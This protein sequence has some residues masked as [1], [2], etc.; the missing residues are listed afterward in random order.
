MNLSK[1][2]FILF[3]NPERVLSSLKVDGNF[4][5]EVRSVRYLGLNLDSHLK[6]EEHLNYVR[7]RT[8]LMLFALRR[9]RMCISE[10]VAWQFYYTHIFSHLL[11]SS[12][13]SASN[14]LLRVL[15]VLQNKAIK[16]V[17]MYGWRHPSLDLYSPTILP[18]N[19]EEVSNLHDHNTRA[20]SNFNIYKNFTKTSLGKYKIFY[21]GLRLFNELHY[22]E[23]QKIYWPDAFRAIL[24]KKLSIALWILQI[25]SIERRKINI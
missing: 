14:S 11:V 23:F 12:W 19:V 16:I 13:S 25:N 9:K 10:R 17:R 5:S 4:I 1:T 20:S 8:W 6:W 22:F 2:N 15:R 21:M 3:R 18:F 24:K 7:K